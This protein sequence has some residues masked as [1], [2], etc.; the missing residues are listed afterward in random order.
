MKTVVFSYLPLQM[1]NVRIIDCI[2]P[3]R[4]PV[5]WYVGP[6]LVQVCAACM[7]HAQSCLTLCNP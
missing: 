7:L 1:I 5:M 2:P 4:L 3:P 6:C